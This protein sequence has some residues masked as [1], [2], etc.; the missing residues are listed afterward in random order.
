MLQ[1]GSTALLAIAMSGCPS[2]PSDHDPV[3]SGTP[4]RTYFVDSMSGSD[5][6]S[7]TSA[8]RPWKSLTRATEARLLPGDTLALAAGQRW[9]NDALDVTE[10]GTA[11]A[12]ITVTRYGSDAQD[13]EVTGRMDGYCFLVRGSYL[14]LEHV[15]A[16]SCGYRNSG[17]Y[18]G[19]AVWGSHDVVRNT[20]VR[21]HAVGV[22]IKAGSDSGLYTHNMLV[23]N[24]V[25]NVNTPG[26]NC[27]T[28]SAAHCGDDSGSFGF[29][30]QGDSNELSWNT[31]TGS[32][33]PSYDWGVDGGAFEIFNGNANEVHHNIAT[34]N[35]NFSELGHAPGH[36]ATKNVFF[37]NAIRATCGALCREA[38]GL[39]VRGEASQYGPNTGT[40]F[41]NNTFYSDGS[42]ARGITCHAR[43]SSAVLTLIGNVIVVTSK[44]TEAWSVWSDAPFT[45]ASNV[46]NGRY[47]GF[48]LSSTSTTAAA[49]FVAAPRDLRLLPTSSAIDRAGKPTVHEDVLDQP[50]PR[51]GNCAGARYVDSGAYEFQP[52]SC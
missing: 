46:L 47:G 7:G 14:V 21:G 38:R 17:P 39:I 50:V 3:R 24:N 51:N 25:E 32:A 11:T 16:V 12:P 4:G 5:A 45:E 52:T 49:R 26:S 23:D 42:A 35:N 33:A 44:A 27:S 18:G 31:V 41:T 43:C 48:P 15:R 1:V 6:N 36:S 30:I 37:Y 8:A 29:L 10:S 22:F 28:H 20:Y 19:I 13:P 9:A 40:V 2:S 34:D